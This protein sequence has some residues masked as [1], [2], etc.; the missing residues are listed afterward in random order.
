MA[1][2]EQLDVRTNVK[3]FDERFE[4]GSFGAVPDDP[5]S[6]IRNMRQH[7]SDGLQQ[8][9]KI[10]ERRET[11]DTNGRGGQLRA[12]IME[13]VQVDAVPN[14][15][16]FVVRATV[17]LFAQPCGVAR[18]ADDSLRQ[19]VGDAELPFGLPSV[20]TALTVLRVDDHWHASQLGGDRSVKLSVSVVRVNNLRPLRLQVPHQLCER[21]QLADL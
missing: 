12:A 13:A 14:R 2:A 11:G 18:D 20:A 17:L 9:G 5:Q 10:F 4:F 8:R 16:E 7:E 19:T 15:R 1:F 21:S 6:E 3:L